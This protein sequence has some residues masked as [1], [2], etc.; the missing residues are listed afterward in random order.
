MEELC[1]ESHYFITRYYARLAADSTGLYGNSVIATD[2]GGSPDEHRVPSFHR[3]G[4]LYCLTEY[5]SGEYVS[6][7]TVWFQYGVLAIHIAI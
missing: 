2:E 3:V 5:F 4:L 6:G 7:A 1:P